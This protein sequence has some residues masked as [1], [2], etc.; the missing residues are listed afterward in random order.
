LTDVGFFAVLADEDLV[1]ELSALLPE[2]PFATRSFFQ[3]KDMLGYEAWIFGQRGDSGRLDFACGAFLKG[4][5]LNRNLEIPSAP[6]VDLGGRF[7]QGVHDFCR[8]RKITIV[9]IGTFG[10]PPE[11]VIPR[12]GR[13]C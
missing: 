7:W 3:A 9:E 2:N 6:R 1:T 11:T 5:R 10:S 8:R 13:S 4:G 12:L